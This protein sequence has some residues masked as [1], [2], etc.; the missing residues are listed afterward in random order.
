M[1]TELSEQPQVPNAPICTFCQ[2]PATGGCFMSPS[3][4]HSTALNFSP[5]QSP[6]A[7]PTNVAPFPAS[8]QEP[9]GFGEMIEPLLEGLRVRRLSWPEGE[10]VFFK[11]E[12]LAIRKGGVEFDLW[13]LQRA[14]LENADDWV[15]AE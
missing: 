9:R 11:N 15:V 12:R 3:G 7:A 14:D 6:A 4:L 1:S 13:H 8:P 10:V 5:S 2:K